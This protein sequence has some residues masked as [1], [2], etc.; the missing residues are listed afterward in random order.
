MTATLHNLMEAF[1]V[2]ACY[3]VYSQFGFRLITLYRSVLILIGNFIAC[4]RIWRGERSWEYQK[5]VRL[6]INNHIAITFFLVAWHARQLQR[7]RWM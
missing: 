3:N 5:K 6:C 7:R 1:A 2:A 4:L